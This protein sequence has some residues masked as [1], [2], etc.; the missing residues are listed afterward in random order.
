MRDR[1][2]RVFYKAPWL[3]NIAAV[4]LFGYLLGWLGAASYSLG[5]L[6]AL[7]APTGW[8][9]E[10]TVLASIAVY[11][12]FIIILGLAGVFPT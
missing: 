11:M 7:L 1:L 4:A 12:I 2:Y 8:P 10:R 9:L 5:A 3:I 6:T